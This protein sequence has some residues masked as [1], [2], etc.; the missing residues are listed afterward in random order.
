MYTVYMFHVITISV[1][2]SLF[3]KTVFPSQSVIKRPSIVISDE[4]AFIVDILARNI[5]TNY[6]SV[7]A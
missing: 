5:V 7:I 6:I 2:P 3:C 4:Q 1:D